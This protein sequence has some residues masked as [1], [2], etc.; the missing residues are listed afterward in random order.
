MKLLRI[1]AVVVVLLAAAGLFFWSRYLRTTRIET[2]SL[3]ARLQ[4]ATLRVGD[5][6]RTF[7]YYVPK[8]RSLHPALVFVFHGSDGDGQRARTAFGY[9]FDRLADEH[10]FIAIYPDGF[11]QHWNDCRKAAPF[12]ANRLDI[13]DVKF[14]RALVDI[15]VR[16]RH[17]D[18]S[19]VFATG[20]SN[21]GQMALRL[22]LEA[23]DLVRAVAAVI[24]SMPTPENLDCKP[25]G[26][27]VSI[28]VMN[29]SADPMNPYEG[30]TVALYGVWGNRGT[31]LSTADTIAYWTKLA[32]YDAPAPVEALPDRDPTDG[33]TVE[34][35]LWQA[36]GRKAVALY[37]IRGG[38]HTVPHPQVR[39]PRILG[40]TNGDIVAAHEIWS[41][42][43]AAP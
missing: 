25:R 17:A 39:P 16:E 43:E 9:E 6:E 11:E 7:R 4:Q 40:A 1:A 31:V 29:G 36:P 14:T 19:R 23:P 42:F 3:S 30:G 33:S 18:R 41:F 22:A 15:F 24:A 21:G 37:T 35:M 8:R 28:L 12:A 2:P 26:E 13:D 32:G 5:R 20:I 27:A 34:R 38:G 10:E